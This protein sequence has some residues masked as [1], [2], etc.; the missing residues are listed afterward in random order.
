MKEKKS[1]LDN[2]LI[3]DRCLVIICTLLVIASCACTIYIVNY[4]KNNPIGQQQEVVDSE[5]TEEEYKKMVDITARYLG[6]VCYSGTYIN[7]KFVKV[8]AKLSDGTRKELA[9]WD[10][11]LGP[12]KEGTNIITIRYRDFTTEMRVTGINVNTITELGNYVLYPFDE[13]AAGRLVSKIKNGENTYDNAFK[14]VLFCGDSRTKALIACQAVSNEK[15]L[16]ENGVGLEHLDLYMPELLLR[17]PK[18]I[19]LNYGVNSISEYENARQEFLTYYKKLLTD[20]KTALPQTR[21]IVA[22]VFPVSSDFAKEQPR[23]YYIDHLNL[24]ILRMCVELD[25]EFIDGTGIIKN[26]DF[27][28]NP[29]GL[30]FTDSFYKNYWLQELIEKMGIGVVEP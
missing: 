4:E 28:I 22:A 11:V 15:V 6:D 21:I 7:S 27:L 2:K 19:I 16:A 1:K 8:Y 30:H 5:I 25:I 17:N 9:N 3:F 18:T 23:M 12:I 14:D 29:D 20:I 26:N 10:A 24:Q 13:A